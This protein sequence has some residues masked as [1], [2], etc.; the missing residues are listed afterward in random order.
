MTAEKAHAI[1]VIVSFFFTPFYATVV[2]SVSW[3]CRYNTRGCQFFSKMPILT[4]AMTGG[5]ESVSP[6]LVLSSSPFPICSHQSAILPALLRS[7]C[8]RDLRRRSARGEWGRHQGRG[9][10]QG[11]PCSICAFDKLH[12][13]TGKAAMPHGHIVQDS[14]EFFSI[15]DCYSSGVYNLLLLF[16]WSF[17]LT[18]N[19]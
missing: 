5:Q 14:V 10:A 4:P 6:S 19:H 3:R 7:I 17:M 13:L 15:G 8:Y 11:S 9:A 2:L 18:M 16:M 1:Y 12:K